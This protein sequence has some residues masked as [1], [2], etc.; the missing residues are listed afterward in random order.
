[1]LHYLAHADPDGFSPTNAMLGLLPALPEG[2]LDFRSI[3]RAGGARAVKAAR[4]DAHR[5]RALEAIQ[6]H[7]LASGWTA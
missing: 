6:I 2:Q 1:L 5:T 4:G 7:L 3:K